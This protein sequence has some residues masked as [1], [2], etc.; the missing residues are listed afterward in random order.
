MI[1]SLV[2]TTVWQVTKLKPVSPGWR[3]VAQ[4]LVVTWTDKSA[5]GGRQASICVAKYARQIVM[6]QKDAVLQG[7]LPVGG[8]LALGQ[9]ADDRQRKRMMNPCITVVEPFGQMVGF[10]VVWSR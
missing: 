8:D 1:F 6:F 5:T 4:V 3:D 7:L 9:L 2:N 10:V